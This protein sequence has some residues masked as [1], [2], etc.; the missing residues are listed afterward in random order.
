V[1][2]FGLGALTGAKSN[3]GFGQ[4]TGT[5]EY[6]SPEA[7]KHARDEE[8]R[9]RPTAK[10]E[11][12]ALG[13]TFYWLLTDRL[14]FGVR[15][16][17]LMTRRVLRKTPKAPHVINPRAP[18]ELGAICMRLLEKNP[19]EC[20]TTDI[21]A[22]VLAEHGIDLTLLK[23]RPP[24]RGRVI[25][26]PV[27][28]LAPLPEPEQVR[29]PEDAAPA[30]EAAAVVMAVPA[31]VP[32]EAPHSPTGWRPRASAAGQLSV[33]RAGSW[34]MMLA[35]GLVMLPLPV[36]GPS[37]PTESAS[38]LFGTTAPWPGG[39]QPN[40][41]V[42]SFVPWQVVTSVQKLEIPQQPPESHADATST[43]ASVVEATI[44]KGEPNVKNALKKASKCVGACCIAGA[45]GCASNTTVVRSDPP[46]PGPC[47]DNVILEMEKWGIKG[48]ESF[49]LKWP[50]S[51]PGELVTFRE[52]E[53]KM[54]GKPNSPRP[55]FR[56]GVFE[57]KLFFGSNRI[58]GNFTK[59]TTPE[60]DEF[61]I[62]AE[63]TGTSG[64]RGDEI[65]EWTSGGAAVI[66]SSLYIHIY[67]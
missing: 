35:L 60:G 1:L 25:K 63:L 16:D 46:P 28:P 8:E 6:L 26:P 29:A 42:G 15:E 45:I 58:Y 34:T 5:L 30:P 17:P 13:V 21:D 10:D 27:P 32:V 12:W 39:F 41:E 64:E 67:F 38:I 20:R 23:V 36:D 2:D 33:R 7:W 66:H 24:R 52:G 18:P 57:G 61:A 22:T 43:R 14:P 31:P 53:I 55:K 9:Y 44:P 37:R 50:G 65:R 47:P 19:P 48:R 3:S 56:E 62:C 59:V 4:V 54:R 49:S 40:E 11:L 51:K